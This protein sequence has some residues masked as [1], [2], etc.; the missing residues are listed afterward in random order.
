MRNLGRHHRQGLGIGRSD[1]LAL[2]WYRKAVDAGSVDAMVDVGLMYAEG[3]QGRRDTGEA[4]RWLQRA[5][6]AGSSRAMHAIGRLY[7]DARDYA[8]AL[9]WY[10]KAADAGSVEAMNNLGVLY[11]NGW[12]VA[13]N[14]AQAARWYRQAAEAGSP[15]AEVTSVAAVRPAVGTARRGSNPDKVQMVAHG[16]E[17]D[18]AAAV[19]ALSVGRVRVV[20]ET[21]QNLG[22]TRVR[23]RQP[24]Q[25]RTIISTNLRVPQRHGGSAPQTNNGIQLHVTVTLMS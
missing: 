13:P 17:A 20:R 8:Q 7:E 19:E 12:G 11:Q 18:L 23:D 21:G 9:A 15:V 1:S 4:L 10:Q 5:A 22:L 14:R 24:S 25:S 2:H 3:V 6:Q 16:V